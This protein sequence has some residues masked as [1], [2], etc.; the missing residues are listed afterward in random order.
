MEI[1]NGMAYSAIISNANFC[2][3][4]N[5]MEHILILGVVGIKIFV[6][7]I[8]I[9]NKFLIYLAQ[10]KIYSNFVTFCL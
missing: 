8:S 1:V 9:V 3:N 5:V 6:M 7:A 10:K 2:R 4:N